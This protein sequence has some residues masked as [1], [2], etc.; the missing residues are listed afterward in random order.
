MPQII[1]AQ[2]KRLTTGSIQRRPVNRMASPAPTTP[3]E[4]AASAAMCRKA[5]R[6]LRSPLRPDMNVSAVTVLIAIPSR[7]TQI[8]VRAATSI[9]LL[10]RRR[11]SHAIA[12]TETRR[13]IALNKA[14]R[15]DVPRS[16]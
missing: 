2:I 7:E 8:T 13:K 10:K 1:T 6:M 9:G 15:M 3:A 4:I 14:A 12:P 5:P 11:A 16:P